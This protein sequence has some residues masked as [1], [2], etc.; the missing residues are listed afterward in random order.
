MYE[1]TTKEN[2]CVLWQTSG[3][4]DIPG[5]ALLIERLN[6]SFAI[7]QGNERIEINY[8]TIPEL[9]KVLKYIKDN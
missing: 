3:D 4:D 6:G 1:I 8:E 7:Q 2:N 9:I 5:Q